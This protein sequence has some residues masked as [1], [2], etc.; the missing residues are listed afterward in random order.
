MMFKLLLWLSAA[1]LFYRTIVS[2]QHW[3]VRFGAAAAAML[4]MVGSVTA[5]WINLADVEAYRIRGTREWLGLAAAAAGPAYLYLWS[6]KH[7]GR[8]RSKT[9]S[10]IAAIIGF[11]PIVAALTFTILYAE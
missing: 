11:L 9:I 2:K 5:R 6:R 8:G 10:L 7:R 4:T 1:V 3:P